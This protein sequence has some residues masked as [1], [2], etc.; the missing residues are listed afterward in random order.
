MIETPPYTVGSLTKEEERFCIENG[1]ELR[2]DWIQ[3]WQTQLTFTEY[4][5]RH[6]RL[7]NE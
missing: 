6:F 4:V 2:E 7:F 3:H 5:R 1:V